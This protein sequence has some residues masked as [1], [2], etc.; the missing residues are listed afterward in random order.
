MKDKKHRRMA[1]DAI[2]GLVVKELGRATVLRVLR[3]I[4]R[5]KKR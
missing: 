5:R 3:R 1:E 2:V 4:K